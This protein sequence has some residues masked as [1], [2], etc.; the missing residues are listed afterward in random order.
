MPRRGKAVVGATGEVGESCRVV[1]SIAERPALPDVPLPSP[2][3][4]NSAARSTR[5]TSACGPSVI[6]SPP[7]SSCRCR[8]GLLPALLLLVLS[9]A[10]SC[11]SSPWSNDARLE[12]EVE[13]ERRREAVGRIRERKDPQSDDIDAIRRS[14]D[15][16]ECE[17]SREAAERTRAESKLGQL[18]RSEMA[19][20]RRLT[21]VTVFAIEEYR[22]C[23]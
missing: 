21:A 3:S 4:T 14:G 10:A 18:G 2:S 7:A 6:A 9:R 8:K 20:S 11:F 17:R 13:A 15:V 16:V 1:K 5:S 12:R 22:E 23:C 19:S